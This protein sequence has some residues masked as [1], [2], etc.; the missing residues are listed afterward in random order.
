MKEMPSSSHIIQTYTLRNG[1]RE[2]FDCPHASH[3]PMTTLHSV[4]PQTTDAIMISA[5]VISSF[6]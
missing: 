1:E 2:A 4:K 5:V 3:T 6:L